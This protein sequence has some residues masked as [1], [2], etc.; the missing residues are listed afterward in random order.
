VIALRAELPAEIDWALIDVEETWGLATPPRLRRH[1]RDLRRRGFGVVDSAP[2]LVLLGR[3]AEPKPRPS[4]QASGADPV[5][6]LR[7]TTFPQAGLEVVGIESLG[8]GRTR[9][10]WR[11]TAATEGDWDLLAF[12]AEGL[13][14][15]VFAIGPPDRPTYVRSAGETFHTELELRL[16]P[17][18]RATVVLFDFLELDRRS[19]SVAEFLAELAAQ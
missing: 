16:E 9:W 18:E 2:P 15:P 1:L 12:G 11:T 17:G 13:V 14:A 19:K 7:Q 8:G 5:L 4:E 3:C 10:S 6:L